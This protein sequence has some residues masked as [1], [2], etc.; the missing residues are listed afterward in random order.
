MGV[1]QSDIYVGDPIKHI[2]KHLYDAWYEEFPDVHY[3]DHEDFSYLGREKAVP[4]TSAKI[5]YSD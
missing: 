1:A 4:S 5:T 3:L 2:Y